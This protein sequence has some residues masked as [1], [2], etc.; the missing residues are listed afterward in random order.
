MDRVL[1]RRDGAAVVATACGE[2]GTPGAVT[3]LP[4]GELPGWVDARERAGPVRWVWDDTTRWYPALLDAGVRVER[5]TDLRLSAAVLRRSPYA[6]PGP[7]A[8]P[9]W[10][11]LEPV[12]ADDPALFDLADPADSLDPQAEHRRQQA[13]VAASPRRDR[14][15]CCWPRSP[16]ARWRPPR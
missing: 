13:A 10:A 6:G 7:A 11:A 3:A 14:L 12:T 8:D 16:P 15:G 9:G 1:L 2:D 5:C 4:A